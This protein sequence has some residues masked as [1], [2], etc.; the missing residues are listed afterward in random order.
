[1]L[2]AAVAAFALVACAWFALGARQAHELSAATAIVTGGP[3]LTAA[4]ARHADSLLSSA[5]TL[6]PDRQVDVL[7]AQ[8]ALEQ[9]DPG[10]AR[11]ILTPVVRQEPDNLSAWVQYARASARDPVA[12]FVAEIAIRRLVRGFPPGG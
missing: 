10:R 5:A 3:T 8:V 1:M 2:R 9:G 12:F 6:N 11:S 7:R 4:Q